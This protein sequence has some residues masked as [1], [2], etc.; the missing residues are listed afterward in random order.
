MD[1]RCYILALSANLPKTGLA[2]AD[3]EV[4]I[5]SINKLNKSISHLV[6]NEA[7]QF[8]VGGGCYGYFLPNAD[9]FSFNYFVKVEYTGTAALDATR[10]VNAGEFFDKGINQLSFAL[11]CLEEGVGKTGLT[12]SDFKVNI[13]QVDADKVATLIVEDKPLT[14]EVGGGFYAYYKDDINFWRYDYLLQVEYVGTALLDNTIW[15]GRVIGIMDTVLSNLRAS[16]RLDL[17]DNEV[18]YRWGNDELDRHIRHAIDE[19]SRVRPYEQKTTLSLTE[20]DEDID[21]SA[22]TPELIR[23]D[24]LEYKANQFPK[25]FKNFTIFGNTLTMDL[26]TRPSAGET[27]KLWWEGLYTNVY[28]LPDY[29]ASLVVEGAGGY[30]LEAYTIGGGRQIANAIDRFA[31]VQASIAQI[32]ARMVQAITD[33]AS[34]RAKIGAKLAEANTAIDNMSTQISQAIS[35]LSEGKDLINT[36]TIGRDPT[37]DLARYA[38]VELNNAASYLAQAR[39]YLAE[40]MLAGEYSGN[41]GRELEIATGYMREAQVNINLVNS[42]ISVSRMMAQY[43][44]LAQMKLMNF[45]NR[46]QAFKKIK[47]YRDYPA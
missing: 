27:A 31:D 35:N 3:F 41:A 10:W 24:K 14:I 25:Q 47:A 45:R 28:P 4:N 29:L 23:I 2:L 30:A 38:T 6:V 37:G 13:R 18:P 1:L 40:D 19:V 33:L 43:I 39:Q 44:N 34:G 17:K 20:G 7:M 21:I 12:L 9:Y 32:S 16:V 42:Q 11:F 8:E 26:A 5:W 15:F 22:I 46:L 36:I